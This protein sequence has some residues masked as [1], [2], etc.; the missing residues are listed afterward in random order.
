MW[1]DLVRI[2]NRIKGKLLF[3]GVRVPKEFDNPYWSKAFVAWLH[4][5]NL[6]SNSTRLTLDY[7]LDQYEMI[8]R[9]FL[10]VSIDVRKLH[11]LPKYKEDAKRLRGI[12][13]IGPLTSVQLLIDIEDIN[14]FR[15]FNH[16]NGYLG[17]KPMVHSS[18]ENDRKGYMTYRANHALRSSL[19][20]CAWTAVQRDPVML[21]CYEDLITKHT[22]KRAIVKIARK[23][24]SRIYR[25][26]ITKEAYEIGVVK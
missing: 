21:S 16:F 24:A 3:N 19:V 7:L 15:N 1:G 8:Y 17:L 11:K 14:R 18:G 22:K 9:H 10:K 4:Q 23:L 6:K 26:L 5:I 12:P 25:V 13:G 2:K 20:E